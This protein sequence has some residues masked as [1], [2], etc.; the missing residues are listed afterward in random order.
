MRKTKDFSGSSGIISAR[1]VHEYD[2]GLIHLDNERI[3][4]ASSASESVSGSKSLRDQ[5]SI[6]TPME[7]MQS[8]SLMGPK[9]MKIYVCVKHVPDTAARITIRAAD[10]WDP[11]DRFVMNPHDE[12]AI[13]QALIVK[14]TCG[15][16]EITAFCLGGEDAEKTLRTALALGADRAVLVTTEKK[17]PGPGFTAFALAEAIRVEGRPDLIFTGSRSVDTEA[18]QTSYR[19]AALLGLPVATEITGFTLNDNVAT[20][21]R[22]AGNGV[23]E[24]IEI[25]L[26]CVIGTARG[27]NIPRPATL[28]AIMRARK[29]PI[30]R[31]SPASLEGVEHLNDPRV[32]ELKPVNDE[33]RGVML[34]GTTDEIASTLADIAKAASAG[35]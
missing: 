19:L 11:G 4:N 2:H 6:P 17:F 3:I 26:P 25:R 8:F 29:L 1:N 15:T 20:V 16:A 28:P 32:L 27:L 31:V 34:T 9:A 14:S 24:E 13:E 35:K 18:M 10:D 12:Y 21:E 33:R 5:A 22:E 7:I 23:I 30:K